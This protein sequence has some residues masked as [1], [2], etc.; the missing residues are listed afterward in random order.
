[1]P[2]QPA[3]ELSNREVLHSPSTQVAAGAAAGADWYV[4]GPS[5]CARSQC[6]T[7]EVGRTEDWW[8]GPV[9]SAIPGLAEGLG[10]IPAILDYGS[11]C[12]G[13]DAPW[14]SLK[15]GNAGNAET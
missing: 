1:M 6:D 4:T 12:S 2:G 13:G 10:L 5:P 11:D 3:I 8:M 7:L 14:F 9:V 15:A